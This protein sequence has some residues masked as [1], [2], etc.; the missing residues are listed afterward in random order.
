[1]KAHCP[2]SAEHDEF[3]TNAQVLEEW[4]VDRDGHFIEVIESLQTVHGPHRDNEWICAIC[5]ALAE[6]K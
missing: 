4:R 6:V 3:F 5:G 1:M 2:N